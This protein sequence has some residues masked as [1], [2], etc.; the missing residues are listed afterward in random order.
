MEIRIELYEKTITGGYYPTPKILR[1]DEIMNVNISRRIFELG[2]CSCLIDNTARDKNL[3]DIVNFTGLGFY[4]NH[5]QVK[6]YIDDEIAFIGV[7]KEYKY[8]E[9]NNTYYFRAEDMLYKIFRTIDA[10]PCLTYENTTAKQ[11]IINLFNHAGISDIKFSDE[12]AD[13]DVK[14]I[15]VEYNNMYID[16][17]NKFFDIMYARFNCNRDGSVDIVKAF[18]AYDGLP[19]IKYKLESVDFISAGEYDRNENDIRNKLIV[20]A[21]D[22]DVQAFEC[23]YLVQHANGE[24]Y[25]D[26]IDED[27]ANTLQ[28]KRNVALKYFRDKLRHSKKFGITT[29][30]G[31]LTRDVGDIT[32]IVLNQSKV[33]AWAMVNGIDTSIQDGIWQDTL[34]LE[35]LVADKWIEPL[36]VGGDYIIKN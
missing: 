24:I 21:N 26:V 33:Q 7:L 28:K 8:D 5:N 16:V 13:Y 30:D 36:P 14:K 23:P 17:L 27:L 11:I 3:T 10:T 1:N 31:N 34:E 18:P 9:D 15:K 12:V 35:I 29:I 6:V 4:D 2:T 25:L 20:K 22:T 19:T 32:R